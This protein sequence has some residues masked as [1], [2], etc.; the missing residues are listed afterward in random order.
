MRMASRVAH[1]LETTLHLV[2]SHGLEAVTHRRVA[3]AAGVS[4]GAISHHFSSRDALLRAT[5]AHAADREVRRLNRLA[6]DL[7]TRLFDTTA[8]IEA[9][10]AALARDLQRERTYRLAQYELLLASARDPDLR[11]LARAWREAHYHVAV[12]GVRAAGSRAP[13]QHGRLLVAAITGLLLKQLADPQPRF[14]TDVLVP[15]LT[16]LVEGTVR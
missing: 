2:G 11:A 3:K 7:Q 16:A 1:I 10:S 12:V 4:L 5:L 15:Q 8:W 6:L 14:E 9:M 13:E